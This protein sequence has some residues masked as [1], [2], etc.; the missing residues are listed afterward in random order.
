MGH[1]ASGAQ[2]R[3]RRVGIEVGLGG[4]VGGGSQV[5]VHSAVA[6]AVVREGVRGLSHCGSDIG[7]L[8]SVAPST[9]CG[10]VLLSL[11][12]EKKRLHSGLD[13]WE[14]SGREEKGEER[15]ERR[16]EGEATRGRRERRGKWGGEGERR[17]GGDG[18]G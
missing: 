15:K 14:R 12:K 8:P 7:L 18:A 13:A 1:S 6:G 17:E 5:G 3:G 11:E 2:G 16:E 10:D 9:V 4:E